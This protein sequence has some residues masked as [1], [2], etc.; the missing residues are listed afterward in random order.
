MSIPLEG[1]T[2]YDASDCPVRYMYDG[3][4]VKEKIETTFIYDRS[5]WEGKSKKLNFTLLQVGK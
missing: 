1:L 5:M 2:V 4:A 3:A